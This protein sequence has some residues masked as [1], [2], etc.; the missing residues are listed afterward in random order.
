MKKTSNSSIVALFV[1]VPVP[2]RVKT[3]LAS[4]LGDEGACSLYR[5]MVADILSNIMVC[6]YPIYLFHD[7]KDDSELPEEWIAGSSRVIHQEGD[8][9]GE[10]MAAAFEQCFAE[11]NEQVLLVGSDIPGLDNQVIFEASKALESHD[12]AIAPAADGGYCL[13]AMKRGS[14]RPNVFQDVPWSSDQV[15]RA[16]LERCRNSNLGVT[17]LKTLQ[18]IDTIED[19][20]A[21]CREPNNKAATTNNCLIAAGFSVGSEAVREPEGCELSGNFTDSD[22]RFPNTEQC[23]CLSVCSLLGTCI[24]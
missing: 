20:K 6:S 1:R 16:T 11:D 22:T 5:S 14:Y 2:G 4:D 18:D 9:I 10:R 13:I 15:L 19:L 12:V 21:Y 23:L 8:S 7:G 3:R 24:A 17:L